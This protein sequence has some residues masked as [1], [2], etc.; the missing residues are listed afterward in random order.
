VVPGP[1]SARDLRFN[2]EQ[3]VSA[4]MHNGGFNCVAAQVVVVPDGWEHTDALIDEIRTVYAETRDR[5]PYYPGAVER[6]DIVIEGP[7]RVETFGSRYPRYLVPHLDA[8]DVG[9]ELF[10]SE[11]FGPV[12]AVTSLPS[13][14]VSSYLRKAVRFAN[15]QLNGTLGVNILIHPRTAR[16]NRAALDR[17]IADLEFGTIAI[18]TWTGVAYFMPRCTWGAYP[19]H[20]RTDIQSGTGFVHNALMFDRAQKSVVR[21]PFA[22][23]ER[24]WSKGEVH[25]AVKPIYFVTNRQANVMGERLI[26]YMDS[27]SKVDIARIASAA[28]R[29]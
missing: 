20:H 2:A 28:I 3:I 17:A 24:A 13:P 15:E 14:D 23:G 25:M 7:E 29:G 6:C 11:V 16:R 22:T 21:G 1:W 10:T 27:G 18:N 8:A 12:L 26:A 4:K 5:L 9:E 19:G